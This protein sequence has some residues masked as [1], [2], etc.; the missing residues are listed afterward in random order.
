MMRKLLK[1]NILIR[2][3]YDGIIA[4]NYFNRKYWQILKWCFNSKENTNY[5]YDLTTKNQD[6]LLKTLESILNIDYLKLK[7]YLNE[8]LDDQDLISH[9]TNKT[10]NSNFKSFADLKVKYS[11]RIGWYIIARALKPRIVVETGVDKGL[12]SIIL[13]S[14]IIRNKKENFEG[15]YFG[16]DIN[17]GAGYLFCDKYAEVGEILYGDSIESLEKFNHTIDLF[18]NDSDHS[19]VYEAN[20]YEAITNKLSESGIILG[21]N[22][23][24]T[25]SLLNFSI[26]NNREFLLFKEEP[27]NH[28]YPG[29]GIGI[30]FKKT[31]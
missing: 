5:T 17:P 29:A 22:S 7:K 2:R 30:S 9:I 21:D 18:I 28:W 10:Q 20:E 19:A 25:S 15:K 11:R 14:A 6:E 16:T 3:L 23:H 12:G 26:K 1:K 31:N 13:S 27:K 4:T 24:S 8:L